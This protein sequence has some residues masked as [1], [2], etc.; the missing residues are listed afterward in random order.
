MAFTRLP[1]SVGGS[2]TSF[3]Q[4]GSS[5]LHVR[6][7]PMLAGDPQVF[8]FALIVCTAL[9]PSFEVGFAT[10]HL[11]NRPKAPCGF[12]RFWLDTLTYGNG[13]N[14]A[15]SALGH[16]ASKAVR[17]LGV[18]PSDWASSAFVADGRTSFLFK[19]L[20]GEQSARSSPSW[21]CVTQVFMP[22]PC[23]EVSESSCLK[24]S[25]VR[26]PSSRR[27]DFLSC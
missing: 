11:A 17:R 9:A 4:V 7:R 5:Q 12:T 14:Q 22:C 24:L 6:S 26:R 16:V 10:Y 8:P 2:P 23:L 25:S 3:Q 15:R 18:E 27:P 19:L 13:P 21:I 1:S 20:F